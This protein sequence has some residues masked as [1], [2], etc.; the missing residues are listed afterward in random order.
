MS[1]RVLVTAG[2]SG[3]GLAIAQSFSTD[4][5]KVF[6]CDIDAGALD[7]LR[8]QTPGVITNVCEIS[9]REDIGQMVAAA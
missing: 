5:A 3:V 9:K 7:A 6:V 8:K 4:G 1:Q 2:A